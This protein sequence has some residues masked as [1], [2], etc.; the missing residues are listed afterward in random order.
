MHPQERSDLIL[1]G[2]TPHDRRRSPGIYALRVAKSLVN[3]ATRVGSPGRAFHRSGAASRAEKDAHHRR[4]PSASASA[5]SKAEPLPW[6]ALPC[7]QASVRGSSA[8]SF[9]SVARVCGACE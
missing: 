8:A 4:V 7:M 1:V 9:S 2:R 3:P 6:K 5:R